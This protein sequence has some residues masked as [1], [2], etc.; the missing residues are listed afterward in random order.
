MRA[1]LFKGHHTRLAPQ[2][3]SRLSCPAAGFRA[4]I[5]EP[6]DAAARHAAHAARWIE[7]CA[8]LLGSCCGTGSCARRQ[9]DADALAA[10]ARSDRA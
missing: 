3:S 6:R 2:S 4:L 1:F 9:N 7:C 8:T 5:E 10:T